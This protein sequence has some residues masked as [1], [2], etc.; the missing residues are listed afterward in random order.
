MSANRL[1]TVFLP[2]GAGPC[3]FMEWEPADTWQGM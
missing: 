2:H 3:F 1:P